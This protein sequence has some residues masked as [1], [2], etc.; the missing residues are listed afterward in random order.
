IFF[1]DFESYEVGEIP[2]EPWEVITSGE[3]EIIIAA[4]DATDGSGRVVSVESFTDSHDYTALDVV[5]DHTTTT[6]TLSFDI[7]LDEL[8]DG[9]F[10][11]IDAGAGRFK[12]GR[13][14]AFMIAKVDNVWTEIPCGDVEP[15]AWQ[16][17]KITEEIEPADTGYPRH[18][19][20]LKFAGA[21]PPEC[22]D[23]EYL[24]PSVLPIPF[25]NFSTVSAP[26]RYFI[27]NVR[28]VEFVEN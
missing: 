4:F 7:Y 3:P 27:D 5:F 17:V 21:S 18:Y 11:F 13:D 1:D 15:G 8:L 28:V 9:D 23:V 22:R 12:I 25:V 16:R 10:V 24:Q 14:T 2:P 19:L 20:S 6:K 26:L